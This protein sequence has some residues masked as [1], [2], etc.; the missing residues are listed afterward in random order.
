MAHFT[1][2]FLSH[3]HPEVRESAA[4][5]VVLLALLAS[6]DRIMPI[7]RKASTLTPQLLSSISERICK[8]PDKPEEPTPPEEDAL[9]SQLTRQVDDLRK[10]VAEKSKPSPVSKSKVVIDEIE[11]TAPKNIVVSVKQEND[12]SKTVDVRDKQDFQALNCIFC[13]KQ[14]FT[15]DS[16]LDEHYRNS[17]RMLSAC[18]LYASFVLIKIQRCRSIVEIPFLTIH[19]LEECSQKHLVGRCSRCSEAIMQKELRGH[20]ARQ[21]CTKTRNPELR[22]PFCHRDVHD[23]KQHN[24]SRECENE[25]LKTRGKESSRSRT[26]IVKKG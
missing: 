2:P 20:I 18:P 23:W 14:G 1:I 19:M 9:V 26:F 5:V 11:H 3:S 10:L 13:D 6:Q 22:C 7:L 4:E 16:E 24:F 21:T 8:V 17:C 12:G 25:K 15:N